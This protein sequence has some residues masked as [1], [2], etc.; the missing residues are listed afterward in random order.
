MMS[1]ERIANVV[2]LFG[3]LI[4]IAGAAGHA[5]TP[6]NQSSVDLVSPTLMDRQLAIEAAQRAGSA[7]YSFSTS[8][9]PGIGSPANLPAY[10][11]LLKQ[12]KN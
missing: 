1:V 8:F 7:T 6:A 11:E 10:D 4:F 9:I 2:V 3:G 5:K 12:K